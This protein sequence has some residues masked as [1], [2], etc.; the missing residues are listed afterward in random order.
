MDYNAAACEWARGLWTS[1][2]INLSM[3]LT[4]HTPILCLYLHI[5][6]DSGAHPRNPKG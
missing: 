1:L 5:V 2:G 6:I 3:E 4:T